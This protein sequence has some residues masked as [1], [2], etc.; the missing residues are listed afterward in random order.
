MYYLILVLFSVGWLLLS[1]VRDFTVTSI[2]HKYLDHGRLVP[3]QK[4]SNNNLG[5]KEYSI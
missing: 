5:G 2:S 4:C 3:I 1:I